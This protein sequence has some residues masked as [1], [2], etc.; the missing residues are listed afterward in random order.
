MLGMSSRGLFAYNKE[1]KYDYSNGK[2]EKLPIFGLSDGVSN[3]VLAAFD[4]NM[5]GL[6][7]VL[8]S[9]FNTYRTQTVINQGD[10]DFEKSTDAYTYDGKECY[11]RY[12]YLLPFVLSLNL[13]PLLS[14]NLLPCY[15]KLFSALAIADFNTLP[16]IVAANLGLY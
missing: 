12:P 4:A 8:C 6:P 10:G 13:L 11:V 14:L 2:F 7:D 1:A 16:I 5:D 3:D 15:P 9:P